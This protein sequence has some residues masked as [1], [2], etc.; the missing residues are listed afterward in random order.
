MPDRWSSSARAPDFSVGTILLLTDGSLFAQDDYTV[1][2]WRLRPDAGGDYSRGSW[3]PAAPAR[4]ARR[5]FAS[6]VLAD[7]RV[8]VAGGKGSDTAGAATDLCAAEIYDPVADSWTELPVP[9]GWTAIGNAPC[10][11]LADGTVLLGNIATGDCAIYNSDSNVWR[12]TGR[13]QNGRAAEECWTLMPDGSVL[14]VDCVGAPQAERFAANEWTTIASPP[15]ALVTGQPRSL[16]AAVLRP[17]GSVFVLGDGAA[18][19]VFQAGAWIAGPDLPRR[20]GQQL[21][22]KDA[23]A[24]LLPDGSILFAAAFGGPAASKY[25]G[26]RCVLLRYDGTAIT[27]LALQPATAD[28]PPQWMRLLLLPTGQVLLASSRSKLEFLTPGGAPDPSSRPE[29]LQVPG[30]VAAGQAY[31]LRGRRLNGLSQACAFGDDAGM[32]TNYPL[33]RLRR[34]IGTTASVAYCRTYGHSSMGVAAPA[35]EVQTT[36]FTL[37]ADLAPGPYLLELVANGIASAPEAVT[38]TARGAFLSAAPAF[39]SGHEPKRDL[40]F[41]QEMFWRELNEVHLLMD[42][43]SGRNDKSLTDLADVR[44]PTPGARDSLTPQEALHRVCLIRF[45]PVGTVE[46]QADQAALL[47]LVKDRLNALASP[48][49]SLSIAFTTM[50][51]SYYKLGFGSFDKLTPAQARV[52]AQTAT[53]FALE[54]YPNLYRQARWFSR[55]FSYLPWVTLIWLFVTVMVSWDVV[56]SAQT[57]NKAQVEELA[58]PNDIVNDTACLIKGQGGARHLDDANVAPDILIACRTLMNREAT[59]M[60]PL[61]GLYAA[62]KSSADLFMGPFSWFHPVGLIVRL[63]EQP[64]P[65]LSEGDGASSSPPN[66]SPEA[67]PAPQARGHCG[68]EGSCERVAD[69]SDFAATVVDLF[70]NNILPMMFGLLG[71]FA[72]LMRAITGKVRDSTLS[73]RDYRLALSLLPMGIVAGLTVGLIIAP[74]AGSSVPGTVGTLSTTALAFLAGYGVEFYFNGLDL[75]LKKLFPTSAILPKD[76]K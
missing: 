26:G 29:I 28:V 17:D 42:F 48:A 69:V 34:T 12:S 61:A 31:L 50:F 55:V 52:A 39:L 33:I 56:L 15:P 3:T 44:D 2:W 5:Y 9:T 18:T 38:V 58:L 53:A 10:C 20:D 67:A 21:V 32:A 75:L 23:P 6:A 68:N 30:H 72:G 47:L 74:N 45:P 41:Q 60:A 36:G 57:L 37:P 19:A 54:A 7:G 66:A 16:G 51:A 11:V 4:L 40:A 25:L 24:C 27:E 62:R 35:T 73:P 71:T 22:A 49:R 59:G 1:N 43:V 8:F 13:K 63:F 65:P 76:T 70:S 14:A 46:D 64:L